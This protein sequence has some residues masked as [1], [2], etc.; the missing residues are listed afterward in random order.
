MITRLSEEEAQALLRRLHL[1]H[2]GCLVQEQPYVVPINYFYDGACVY[3][4]SLPGLKIAAL[5]QNPRACLQVDEIS[6]PYK[7]YSVQAFGV[8]EELLEDEER[9]HLLRR[10]LTHFP[11]LTPVESVLAQEGPHLPVIV[12]RLRIDRLQ[13]LAET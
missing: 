3:M 7:W 13:G 1:G 9:A 12:F 4:H 11:T 8:Y 10:L 6:S 2:L 5:R